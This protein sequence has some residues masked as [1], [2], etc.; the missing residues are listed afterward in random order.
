MQH[1]LQP[2]SVRVIPEYSRDLSLDFGNIG[3]CRNGP[4]SE[5]VISDPH[6]LSLFPIGFR[7]KTLAMTLLRTFWAKFLHPR[8]YFLSIAFC[9]ARFV[10]WI[11]RFVLQA[12]AGIVFAR[13]LRRRCVMLS[14]PVVFALATRSI[15]FSHDLSTTEILKWGP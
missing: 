13:V 9:R 1:T 3:A 7:T 10:W 12:I 2:H 15:C 5:R 11:G 6:P 4:Q 14:G 8:V